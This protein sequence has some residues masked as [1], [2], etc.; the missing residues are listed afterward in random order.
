MEKPRN[1]KLLTRVQTEVGQ[2][3]TSL[4]SSGEDRVVFLPQ[5]VRIK[6]VVFNPAVTQKHLGSFKKLHLLSSNRKPEELDSLVGGGLGH[7]GNYVF[8][9]FHEWLRCTAMTGNH[10]I[11]W[12]MWTSN[13]WAQCQVH[14]SM[15]FLCSCDFLDTA[16][17]SASF[18]LKRWCVGPGIS[19]F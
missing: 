17:D 1:Q 8:L 2:T 14:T 7:G 13:H 3:W 10:W 18:L 15:F 4:P 6:Q 12:G 5:S 19:Q 11:R 9:R 16:W